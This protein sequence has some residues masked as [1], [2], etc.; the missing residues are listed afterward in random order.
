MQQNL[1]PYFFLTDSYEHARQKEQQ[2]A[3]TSDLTTDEE[4][5]TQRKRRRRQMQR[6]VSDED[7]VS[8]LDENCF[9]EVPQLPVSSEPQPSFVPRPQRPNAPHACFHK[10]VSP[11]PASEQSLCPLLSAVSS[12]GESNELN[13][14]HKL[15]T[16][17]GNFVH[18]V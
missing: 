2:A 9:V 18:T 4:C 3:M 8:S 13:D 10:P 11:V 5:F 1:F 16:P 7:S 12:A 6:F 14:G 17:G 15:Q